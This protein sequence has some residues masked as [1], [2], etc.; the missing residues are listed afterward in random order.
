MPQHATTARHARTTTSSLS[1]LSGSPARRRQ[2]D[3]PFLLLVVLLLESVHR[4]V[5]L[6]SVQS[7]IA[8]EDRMKPEPGNLQ[9]DSLHGFDTPWLSLPSLSGC[10]SRITAQGF[11]SDCLVLTPKYCTACDPTTA[12]SHCE[13]RKPRIENPTPQKLPSPNPWTP[14]APKPRSPALHGSLLELAS[15][16]FA[17]CEQ[18]FQMPCSFQRGYLIPCHD[19]VE[20]SIANPQLRCRLDS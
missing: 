11:T 15:E 8:V 1:S 9:A 3:T 17:D 13:G 19:A 4:A 14:K 20:Y 16:R 12:S 10:C 6:N 7:W 2:H 5:D 18:P